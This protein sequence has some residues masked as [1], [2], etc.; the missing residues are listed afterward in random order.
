MRRMIGLL[1]V[2]AAFVSLSLIQSHTRQVALERLDQFNRRDPDFSKRN[3]WITS[4]PSGEMGLQEVYPDRPN[5][6][7]INGS[8]VVLFPE[9]PKNALS[10]EIWE[11]TEGKL[12]LLSSPRLFWIIRTDPVAVAVAMATFLFGVVLV[13]WK[14]S[15][16]RDSKEEP[17]SH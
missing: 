14:A 17:V 16:N 6:K 9:G 2:L 4:T 8:A 3:H 5:D 7:F 12:S 15:A 11:V 1:L 13:L 10:G